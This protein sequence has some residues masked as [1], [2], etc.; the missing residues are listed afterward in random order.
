V[1]IAKSI[2]EAGADE[3]REREYGAR[4]A[5]ADPPLREQVEA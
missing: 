1:P 3:R 5:R 2:R 4:A